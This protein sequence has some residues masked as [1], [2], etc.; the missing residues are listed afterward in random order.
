MRSN[1]TPILRREFRTQLR[2]GRT[3]VI[4][5]VYV[6]L[7]LLAMFLLYRSVTAR[8]DL[9][10]PLVNAQIGQAL[11]TGLALAIQ[12][13]TVFLAPAATLDVVSREHEHDT[14]DMLLVT[15]LSAAQ[16]LWGKLVAAL[17]FLLLLLLA[18]LPL[19][20]VVILFGGIGLADIGRVLAT[21][22][23]SA[24]L[25]GILGL[26]CSA[27]TKQTFTATMLCYAVLVTLV[28]GTLFAAN[29]W[30]V[31]HSQGNA[32]AT[33][34]VANPL[35]AVAAALAGTAP[36]EIVS[37]ASLGPI[38]ILGLLTQ[39]TIRQNAGQL[40]VL[41][42]FRATWLLYGGAS[43]L[44][45]WAS[46]HLVRQRGRWRLDRNDLVL[47]VLVVGYAALVYATRT[48]WQAGLRLP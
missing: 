1:I 24:L 25:G 11:F 27:A 30:S 48:W 45:F 9:G 36:P 15:P 18:T 13:L 2:G 41:P 16:I 35:S 6:G 4:L 34:V 28:G 43:L 31:T 19:F 17:A 44:L 38:A 8:I 46:I 3:A 7:L 14:L 22:L 39:G 20:S 32:P 26:F 47:C 12:V 5:T 23:I 42:L 10:A 33:Y 29:L 37:A 40:S 21:V